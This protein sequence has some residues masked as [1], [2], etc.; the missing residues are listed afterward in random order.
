MSPLAPPTSPG[1]SLRPATAASSSPGSRG[2]S[3]R[4]VLAAALVVILFAAAAGTAT[5]ALFTAQTSSPT[6]EFALGTV[7]LAD[8]DTDTTLFDVSGM[9]P[10]DAPRS[11]CVT[12]SYQGSLGANVRLYA[13][14]GG[15]L[16]QYVTLTVTRGAGGG[17]PGD[18]SACDGF[19][20]DSTDYVGQGAGVVYS[21]SLS[22][23]PTD[24][25]TGVADPSAGAQAT[26]STSDAHAYKFTVTLANTTAA[27]GLTSTLAFTWEAQQ[28]A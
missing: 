10:S 27:Q 14:V 18:A 24:W 20:A 11:N 16:A 21:G 2:G 4:S 3:V 9:K 28:T 23:F 25:A 17:A 8:N 6:N 5:W 1:S 7:I 15:S 13:S 22:A 26:W 19:A 12:V